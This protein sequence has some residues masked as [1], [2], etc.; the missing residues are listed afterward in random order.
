LSLFPTAG[1]HLIR[2][3]A[4]LSAV[5]IN[6]SFYRPHRPATYARWASS[7]P[8]NFRFAVKIPKLATH[9]RRLV[10]V[11]DVLDRFLSEVTS[12]GGKLGPLLIQLPPTLSFTSNVA[13]D[14]LQNYEVDST[15]N[16]LWSPGTRV[17]LRRIPSKF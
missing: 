16:S 8:E 10:D 17:G 6:S 1:T 11:S 13:E 14:F 9:E 5:E 2:Y 12:L 3:A 7:V 15:A 4:A